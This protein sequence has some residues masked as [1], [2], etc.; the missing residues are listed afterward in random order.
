MTRCHL[1]GRACQLVSLPGGVWGKGDPP[2][3]PMYNPTKHNFLQTAISRANERMNKQ[4]RVFTSK[5]A[6][7]SHVLGIHVVLL[8]AILDGSKD[9]GPSHQ[10]LLLDFYQ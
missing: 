6:Q 2:V 8:L 7:Q 3:L 10:Q 5:R 1:A 9:L 4:T